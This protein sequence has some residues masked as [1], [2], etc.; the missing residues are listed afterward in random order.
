MIHIRLVKIDY[1]GPLAPTFL[2]KF[3][4]ESAAVA[5]SLRISKEKPNQIASL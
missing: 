2:F 4:Q 5:P 3:E 1:V